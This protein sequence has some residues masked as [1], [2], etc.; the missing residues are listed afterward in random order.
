MRLRKE[1]KLRRLGG[2]YFIVDPV[3][4]DVDLARIVSLNETAAFLWRL[5]AERG[6]DERLLA[7]ALREEYE[8]DLET[9]IKDIRG[10]IGQWRELGLVDENVGDSS[11]GVSHNDKRCP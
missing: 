10:V 8:V 2:K 1:L 9:A 11:L 7:Q 4:E 6:L 5:A 3:V